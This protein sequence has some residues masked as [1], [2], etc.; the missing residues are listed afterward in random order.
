MQNKK[1][2][3]LISLLAFLGIQT[4]AMAET[5]KFTSPTTQR[6]TYFVGGQTPNSTAELKIFRRYKRTLTLNNCGWGRFTKSS[7]ANSVKVLYNSAAPGTEIGSSNVGRMNITE[8]SAAPACT[9][10]SEGGYTDSLASTPANSAIQVGNVIWIKGGT[11][12]G[13]YS[14]DYINEIVRQAKTNN[15]GIARLSAPSPTAKYTLQ[16]FQIGSYSAEDEGDLAMIQS[17]EVLCRKDRTTGN[18]IQFKPSAPLGGTG[19][20]KLD[21]GRAFV[22]GT[23]GSTIAIN[24]PG[25]PTASNPTPADRTTNVVINACGFKVVT[26]TTVARWNN[27]PKLGG[28]TPTTWNE[29]A[30][31]AS[32][33][34]YCRTRDAKIFAPSNSW[35]AALGVS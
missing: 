17:Q 13:T 8:A 6:T 18:G 9:S 16:G 11:A 10:N 14:I 24:Y 26:A 27:A 7:T 4:Q 3:A 35:V 2:I 34:P 32:Q 5:W 25:T 29:A 33:L 21:D 31:S 22:I 30:K 12:P 20:Y 15:C 23:P 1:N 19:L 28:A